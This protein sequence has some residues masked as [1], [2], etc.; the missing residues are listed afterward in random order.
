MWRQYVFNHLFNYQYFKLNTAMKET[1]AKLQQM[2]KRI[3]RLEDRV[4]QIYYAPGMPGY[5]SSEKEFHE[6]MSKH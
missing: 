2:I 6:Y 1:N 3:E 4:N 5:L